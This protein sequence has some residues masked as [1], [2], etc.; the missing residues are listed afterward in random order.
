MRPSVTKTSFTLLIL[1]F[2]PVSATAEATEPLPG[3]FL[4]WQRDPTTTMTVQWLEEADAP[5][6]PA[7]IRYWEKE[8]METEQ[9]EPTDVSAIRGWPGMFLHRAELTGLV[10]AAAYRFRAGEHWREFGFRTMPADLREPLRIGIGGDNYNEHIEWMERVN[11]AAM[12]HRPDFIVWGGDLAYA[13]ARP[14]R[15]NRWLE[16]FGTIQSSLTDADGF[17]LPVVVAIGNHEVLAGYHY[18][19]LG[20]EE[21]DDWRMRLAPFFYQ[22]FAFPGQPGYNVL[23][24]GNYLSLVILDSDHSNPTDGAQVPWLDRVLRERRHVPH[25]FPVYHFPGYPGVAGAGA[26]GEFEAERVR[27]HWSPL[28][29]QHGVQV[30]FEHHG[31]VYKRTVPIR[32]GRYHPA[33]VVYIGDGAWGVTVNRAADPDTRWYLERTAA[34]RHAV[35]ATLHGTHRHFLV[36]DEHGEVIDEFPAAGV[37]GPAR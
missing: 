35:I 2:L 3:L 20:Y 19:H 9:S 33:G 22:L 34:E 6:G 28:F 29:E 21:T 17:I 36:V 16:W 10:S 12:Y 11:R 18:G 15:V 4:T 1:A 14:D 30:A 7:H 37:R 13:N 31:H 8:D 26:Y 27:R 5:P 23:D 25:V 32:E 24:F